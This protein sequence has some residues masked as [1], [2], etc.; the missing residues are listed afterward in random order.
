MKSKTMSLQLQPSRHS[1]LATAFAM[2]LDI[3][4]D[5]LIHDLGHDGSRLLF[6]E[7]GPFG[8]CGHHI[9]ELLDY[10]LR[11]GIKVVTI[12]AL[13]LSK[14]RG[15]E[16]RYYMSEEQT[17]ERMAHYIENYYGVLAGST[18]NGVNH[19]VAW[20]GQ[21]IYNPSGIV[22]KNFEHIQIMHFFIVGKL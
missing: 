12:D 20:N 11:N 13:P 19:A 3:N 7:L 4:V 14:Y 2:A 15:T 8:V 17:N 6:P 18:L 22:E 1:C 16:D 21:D 5:D 10:C 9:Q